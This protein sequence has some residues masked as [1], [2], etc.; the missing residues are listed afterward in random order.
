MLRNMFI[1][2]PPG[3]TD[4]ILD[5]STRETG[6]MFFTPRPPTS[7]TIRR[8]FRCRAVREPTAGT[9]EPHSDGSLAIG[10][11]K[12]PS[13]MNNL[14]RKLAPITESAWGEIELEA[15]RTFKRTSPA[16]GWSTSAD[17]ADR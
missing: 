3:N 15:A 2:D 11:L 9:D 13:P 6:S 1:G 14:Y 17:R 7:S 8:H 16:A 12:G 5:F 4:R 10:S